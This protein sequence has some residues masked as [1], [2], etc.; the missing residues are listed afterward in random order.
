[1]TP[2]EALPTITS[3]E[4]LKG[5]LAAGVEMKAEYTAE[6]QQ[7]IARKKVELLREPK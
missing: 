7:A 1:M 5:Y 6:E 4:E 3:M 2:I